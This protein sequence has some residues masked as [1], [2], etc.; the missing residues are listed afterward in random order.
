MMIES[1]RWYYFSQMFWVILV[2]GD[3]FLYPTCWSSDLIYNCIPLYWDAFWWFS[4][5]WVFDS[6]PCFQEASQLVHPSRILP[7]YC[8][9]VY[10]DHFDWFFFIHIVS[11][12]VYHVIPH[13]PKKF[14]VDILCFGWILEVVTLWL[15]LLFHPRFSFSKPHGFT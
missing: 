11:Y 8:R 10:F 2:D 1:R 6:T 15:P 12:G 4:N 3:Y 13:P 7:P 5:F 14:Q 9:L